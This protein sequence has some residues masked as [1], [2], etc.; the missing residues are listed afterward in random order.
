MENFA[1]VIISLA[2]F[3]YPAMLLYT[4]FELENERNEL[5]KPPVAPGNNLS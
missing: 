3:M 1:E 5:P 2:L 4:I